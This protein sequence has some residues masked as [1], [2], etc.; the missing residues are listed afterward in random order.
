MAAK[1]FWINSC[2]IQPWVIGCTVSSSFI[3]YIQSVMYTSEHFKQ[4]MNMLQ[5][6]MSIK[7]L[8]LLN[9][10]HVLDVVRFGATWRNIPEDTNLH[11]MLFIDCISTLSS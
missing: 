7:H 3:S 8:S 6:L 11:W 1:L 9:N 10:Y 4:N 2:T 5:R